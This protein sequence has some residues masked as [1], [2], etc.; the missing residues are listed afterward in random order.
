MAFDLDTLTAEFT[1]PN[2]QDW[3]IAEDLDALT[4]PSFDSPVNQESNEVLERPT[5]PNM[6][7]DNPDPV[8]AMCLNRGRNTGGGAAFVYW[9][10]P[11]SDPTGAF[12][13]GSVPWSQ[14]TDVI[15]VGLMYS[16]T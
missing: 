4:A 12:Y 5:V 16:L 8:G 15:C 2:A 3:D 6:A 13:A 7:L 11:V 14:L 10:S 1:D 9:L